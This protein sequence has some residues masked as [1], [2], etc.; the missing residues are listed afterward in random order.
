MRCTE[1][2]GLLIS[3]GFEIRNGKLGSHK[4]FFHDG[5]P[6]F[7][8]GSYNCEHGLNPQIKRPYIIKIL[9][10]LREHESDLKTFLGEST[11]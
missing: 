7:H 2:T 9:R 5:L 1:L 4:V 10:I 3:L 6:Q 11:P 8:S